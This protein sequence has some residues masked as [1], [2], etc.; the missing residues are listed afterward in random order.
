MKRNSFVHPIDQSA[1]TVKKMQADYAS[2]ADTY[3]QVHSRSAT[4]DAEAYR[5]LAAYLQTMYAQLL[6][7]RQDS[8]RLLKAKDQFDQLR[9][10]RPDISSD[11]PQWKPFLAI[12]DDSKA[13]L[14]D[15]NDRTKTYGTASAAWADAANHAGIQVYAS[16]DMKG[17]LQ[18]DIDQVDHSVVQLRAAVADAKNKVDQRSAVTLG[19]DREQRRRELLDSM[20][21]LLDRISAKEGELRG[22]VGDFETALGAQPKIFAGPGLPAVDVV[23]KVSAKTSEID[24]LGKKLNDVIGQWNSENAR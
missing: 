10:G 2:K 22:L 7:A 20:T 24:D 5:K 17:K 11:R 12:Y 15:F 14:A 19:L 1:D 18:G 6:P 3:L 8:D 4:P 13:T 23:N 21:G 9:Q 16:A